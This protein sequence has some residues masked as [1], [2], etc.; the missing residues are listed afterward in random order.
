MITSHA[1]TILAI[2]TRLA[3]STIPSHIHN[4]I[5]LYIQHGVQPGHCLSAIFGGDLYGA[6][7]RADD[8]V[9]SSMGEIVRF[10][11]SAAPA[12]CYGSRE[13]VAIWTRAGGL[14]GFNGKQQP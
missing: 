6:Y 10:I 11:K 13:S 3:N 8:E 2:R 7:A 12:G 5:M 14:D 1:D 9:A 4:S